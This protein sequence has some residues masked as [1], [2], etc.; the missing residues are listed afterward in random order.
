MKNIAE[1]VR[2]KF[3]FISINILANGF[4]NVSRVYSLLFLVIVKIIHIM[5]LG[6]LVR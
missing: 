4:S 5:Y 1:Q 3:K 6:V 2:T